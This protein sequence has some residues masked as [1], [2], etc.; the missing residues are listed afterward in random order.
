VSN[1]HRPNARTAG[2]AFGTLGIVFGDIGTSP[3]YAFR[4]AF[5]HA[6]LEITT[7]STY[8]VASVAFWALVIVISAKYLFLVM[9]AD[10][11][12]EGGILALTALVMP[13]PGQPMT[14]I[15]GAVITLG[16]FGTALLYGDGLITPAISV[17]SAVE[18]FEVATSAFTDWVLPLAI[19]ILVALFA[20]QRRGT[21][22][23]AKLFSPVMVVW[24]TTL[25]VIGVHEITQHPSVLRAVSPTYAVD[26]FVEYPWRAFL[27]LGSI[28][29]VVTGGE[30]LYADMGHFGRRP[31][32]IAW[33]GLVL[34]GLILNYFGQAALLSQR[35]GEIGDLKPF[36]EMAPEWAI[37]PLAI[38]ATM[39][40]VIASQALI[41]GAF[42]LTMQAVQ[43][44][45][46][47][48]LAIEHT[49]PH[50]I[51]QVYVPLV[52][53]LLM[54][55]CVGLVVTFQ[56][57]S[58]LASAYG[59][60][61]TTTMLITTLIF[62]RVVRDRWHWSVP[63]A[64]ATLVPFLCV[65]IAF[66]AANVP[67]IPEGGWFPLLVGFGLVVQMVTWRKGRQLVAARIRRGE[68]PMSEVARE[69]IEAKVARVP[70]TAVYLFKDAGA[71]PP[72]LVANLR[73]N[74]VLHEQ[75][76]LVSVEVA[77]EPR[78]GTR[79]RARWTRVGPGIV[80]VRLSFGF[81]DEPDVPAAL[82]RLDVA[83]MEF[84]PA[85][86]TYFL[87][88]ESVTSGKVPGMHPW[89]EELFVLL[90]R[91]AA[92]ASRFFKLPS[93]QVFEVGTHVEI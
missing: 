92:N 52:N 54:I 83:G 41:S 64:L 7:T 32:Q 73:H 87:G 22:G 45:Y 16:V 30:A 47:P 12:G 70:G 55:G 11:E 2:L 58:A 76:L 37:V 8:G 77:D 38:L 79:R 18:G 26:F 86:A 36:Y 24:F 82:A 5:H 35:S 43:L 23:M 34:P 62:Y 1:E 67:K 15:G 48:R 17:L 57:S 60:A 28:F 84:D 78:V 3:I 75:T 31:I 4:E 27:A 61:V 81:M 74:K 42:S 10:N 33:Y 69:A 9:R 25:G 90:N 66:L 93:D 49:S 88:R 85:K 46:F 14:K 71:A 20:V 59:I 72:A 21:A 29:L 63:R 6:E 13:S 65:D 50:H 53:W 51:G 89:R 44:D 56:T 19:V 68:R 40:T 91:G 80:Q 39:A